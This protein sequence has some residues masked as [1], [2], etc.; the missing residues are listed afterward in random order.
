MIRLFRVFIPASV[1]ALLVS[2][3]VLLSS[4]YAVAACILLEVD[5]KIFLLYDDGWVRIAIV[6]LCLMAGTY[7]HDLYTE[8]R[9]KSK[10]RLFQQ[11][12][13]VVGAAFLAQAFLVY[14]GL[15]NLFLPNWLMIAGSG[16]TL[17]LLPAWH[18]FFVRVACRAIGAERILF[19]GGS[20]AIQELGSHFAEHPEKGLAAIGRVDDLEAG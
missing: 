15:Q 5:P 11:I 20:P 4:C 16:L 7:F 8:F 19:L 10:T 13:V 18:I 6:V 2:D 14:L 3:A 12:A 1:I 9:L 17:V